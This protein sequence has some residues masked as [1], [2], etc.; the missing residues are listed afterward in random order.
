MA[1]P[2][3]FSEVYWHHTV[4]A[5]TA[6]LRKVLHLAFGWKECGARTASE[7]VPV[8]RGDGSVSA[9]AISGLV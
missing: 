5:F 2:W 7:E 6:M 3:G 1:E 8:G 4:R 9:G